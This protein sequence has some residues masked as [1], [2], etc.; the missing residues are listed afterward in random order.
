MRVGAALE[1]LHRA[2]GARPDV[3]A[4][5]AADPVVPAQDR[6]RRAFNRDAAVLDDR[7][8]QRE[9]LL[10]VVGDTAGR[11]AGVNREIVGAGQETVDPATVALPGL[12]GREQ[13]RY[14]P[15]IAQRLAV[16]AAQDVIVE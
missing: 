16:E 2:A 12:L 14:A 11:Q 13:R 5:V 3:R 15:G 10:G 6:A 4:I 1:L 9:G 7:L 8:G